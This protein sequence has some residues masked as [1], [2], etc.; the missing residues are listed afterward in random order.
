MA[1]L[2]P[3]GGSAT[4]PPVQPVQLQVG[5]PL[6]F[7]NVLVSPPLIQKPQPSREELMTEVA[8]LSGEKFKDLFYYTFDQHREVSCP[9]LFGCLFCCSLFCFRVLEGRFESDKRK[10]T[11]QYGHRVNWMPDGTRS[12]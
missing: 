6:P 10:G 11:M 12:E 8:A 2:G 4:Q 1:H 9:V 5:Q 3:I 7:P